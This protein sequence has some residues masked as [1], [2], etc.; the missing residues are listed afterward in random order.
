MKKVN[1]EQK[2][3][4]Y[5]IKTLREKKNLT[6][7]QFAKMLK[8]SQSAVARMESG[9]QNFTT[10]ELLKISEVL[11]HK[12]IEI[13]DSV[14]LKIKG[15]KKLKGSVDTNTSKNGALSLMM[16]SVLN[17]GKTTL[18]GV[19][20]IEEINRVVELFQE[21]GI[22]VT[23]TGE[24]DM[25]IV[26]PKKI[27]KSGLM[28]ESA[29]KIRSGLMMIGPLLHLEKE[30]KMPN[31]G[32]CKMGARTIS[33][34]KM[35]LE[36]LGAKI[37]T[38]SDRYEIKSNKLKA[39][40]VV[41]YEMSDTATINTILA[42]ALIPGE[43]TI[44]FAS[45]NYHVQDTCFFL[46][47]MGLKIEGVG[48]THLKVHGVSEIKSNI[49]HYVSEDPIESMMFITAGIITKSEMTIK[50][51]PIDF[52]TLEMLKLEKMGLK[53]KKSKIYKSHNER[54]DL[55]DI[56]LYPSNLKALPDKIHAQPYPGINTDNLPFF[57]SIATQAKGTTL[58]HDWMWEN[59][60]IYFTELNRLGAQVDLADPHRV[61]IHG[62]TELSPSQIVCPPAL[63]PATIILVAML[64]AKGESVL[65]NVY[66]IRRGYEDIA[67]RLNKLGADIEVLKDM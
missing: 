32:G 22:K 60:A 64:A 25:E 48:T 11:N 39:S 40:E 54:T 58:I 50:R 49:E 41:L 17:K 10:K 63:R 1:E 61:F 8:T 34:H 21:V 62:K 26:I 44:K 36:E 57:A 16:C 5:L 55:V 9:G 35:A 27:K 23:W 33:A 66:S 65:R 59:R 28:S 12:I 18:H 24:H 38:F 31:A 67:E 42:A 45:S 6:Q 37:E 47:K 56:T 2:K 13:S 14:D 43:T 52:L 53:Y 51:C 4:G 29:K 20:R 30:F 7:S 3:L 19:P 15:G 46:E